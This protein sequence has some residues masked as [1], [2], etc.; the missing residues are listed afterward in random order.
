MSNNVIAMFMEI[1][2]T[3]CQ[4]FSKEWS[5]NTD[6]QLSGFFPGQVRISKITFA[7]TARPLVEFIFAKIIPTTFAIELQISK[8][9]TVIIG[10]LI[11]TD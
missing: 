5:I 7:N 6:I 9:V 8:T 3:N 10:D 2:G 1:V 11:A 4:A